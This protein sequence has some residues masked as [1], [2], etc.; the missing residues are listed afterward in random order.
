MDGDMRASRA[1]LLVAVSGLTGSVV[2]HF[3]SNIDLAQ[4]NFIPAS[5][6]ITVPPIECQCGYKNFFHSACGV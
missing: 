6:A 4:A 5:F 2:P 1:E 3:W